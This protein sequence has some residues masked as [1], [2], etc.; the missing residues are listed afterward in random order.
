MKGTTEILDLLKG[1]EFEYLITVFSDLTSFLKLLDGDK[2]YEKYKNKIRRLLNKSK[3]FK[4]HP[5]HHIFKEIFSN[6]I[7]IDSIKVNDVIRETFLYKIPLFSPNCIDECPDTHGCCHSNY[8]VSELD[9]I[10]IIKEDLLDPSCFSKK[11]NK[12]KLK[13]KRRD[14][15]ITCIALDDGSRNC[16][17]HKYKPSTCC[18]YPI[19]NSIDKWDKKLTSWVGGCAHYPGK[20]SWGTKVAPIVINSL[21]TLWI[22]ALLIWEDEYKVL[23]NNKEFENDEKLKEILSYVLGLRKSLYIMSREKTLKIFRKRFEPK[24]INYV[25]DTIQNL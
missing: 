22:K 20:K 16:L 3:G 1:T 4:N 19:I 7:I 15:V 14:G 21:R 9:Y 12:Y 18:K 24:K 6:S 2:Y 23:Q 10:R 17:I 25:I 8:I 13:T 11:R 5:I